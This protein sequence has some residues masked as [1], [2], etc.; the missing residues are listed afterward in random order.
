MRLLCVLREEEEY[1]ALRLYKDV[2]SEITYFISVS[3]VQKWQLKNVIFK[4]LPWIS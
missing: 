4:V 3:V 1:V 2:A